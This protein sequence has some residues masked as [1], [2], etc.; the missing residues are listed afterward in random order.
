MNLNPVEIFH[1]RRRQVFVLDHHLLVNDESSNARP[2]WQHQQQHRWQKSKFQIKGG[3]VECLKSSIHPCKHPSK[4]SKVWIFE[5][6]TSFNSS[7][8][9]ARW[10]ISAVR[11]P[12][13]MEWWQYRWG[14]WMQTFR[15][16]SS[17]LWVCA[18]IYF[19]DPSK[20]EKHPPC[21]KGGGDP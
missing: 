1:Q 21:H 4:H 6:L 20:F 11:Q 7:C 10:H 13:S 12:C 19:G 3:E 17:I 14:G 9:I 8:C 15:Y 5:Q 18:R 16:L 2:F